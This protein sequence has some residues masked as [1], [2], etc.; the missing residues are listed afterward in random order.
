MEKTGL[1]NDHA[2][3]ENIFAVG[4]EDWLLNVLLVDYPALL[5]GKIY[6]LETTLVVNH[7]EVGMIRNRER[8]RYSVS[9]CIL[10]QN[11]PRSQTLMG[12]SVLL[13][14]QTAFRNL[15]DEIVDFLRLVWLSR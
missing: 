13:E 2:G 15:A 11:C 14:S 7:I 10:D 4:V 1:Q 3:R 12:D 5:G 9:Q 6:V 8:I